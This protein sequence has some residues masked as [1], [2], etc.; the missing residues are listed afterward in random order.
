MI[1]G[2][3]KGLGF[4]FGRGALWLGVGNTAAR[5]LGVVAQLVLGAYLSD[6]DFGVFALATGL[7]SLTLCLRGGNITGYLQTLDDKRFLSEAGGFI[8]LSGLACL[9]GLGATLLAA[10]WAPSF[11]AARDIRGVLLVFAIISCAPFFSM[12]SRAYLAGRLAFGRLAVV[13]FLSALIRVGGAIVLA[14]LGMGAYALVVPIAA[15]GIVEAMLLNRLMPVPVLRLAVHADNTKAAAYTVRWTMLAAVASTMI[16]QGDYLGAS[17]FVSTDVLGQYF[18]AYALCNQI[19]Y[20]AT[21]MLGGIVAPIIARMGDD[22]Q[23]QEAAGRRLAASLALVMPGILMTLPI[24]FPEIDEFVWSGRWGVVRWP[25][26]LIA[27]HLACLLTTTLL[28]G[29][30]HGRGH[31]RMP[32]LLDCIRA[33]ALLSGAAL[34]SAVFHTAGGIALGTL[35]LGGTTSVF[36]S[37]AVA[38]ALGS[39]TG[40]ALKLLAGGPLLAFAVAAVI[41]SGVDAIQGW[42]GASQT[43]DPRWCIEAVAAVAAFFIAY[44]ATCRLVF[45]DSTRDLLRFVGH[46]WL[47]LVRNIR[48]SGALHR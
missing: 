3:G 29:A 7:T 28:Y 23:R 42:S 36:A 24:A 1:H 22:Q 41:R 34:G 21:S 26:L 25:L 45:P 33:V 35:L 38:R 9:I 4:D 48:P 11:V 30:L 47:S 8:R 6:A 43:Q 20:L 37:V 46:T 44:G 10:L 17:Y 14:L 40:A 31:F 32:A 39:S 15:S 12:P 13:D 2:M 19:G 27:P 16:Y 18:F 5:A